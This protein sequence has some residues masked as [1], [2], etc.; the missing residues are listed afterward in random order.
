M[1]PLLP[2]AVHQLAKAVAV[3]SQLV[4][5]TCSSSVS[6]VC[7]S[8]PASPLRLRGRT[9]A[10]TALAWDSAMAA[11]GH[12]EDLRLLGRQEVLCAMLA[13][14]NIQHTGSRNSLLFQCIMIRRPSQD[15]QVQV[16]C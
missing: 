13:S 4:K 7:N 6:S 10:A 11:A 9:C 8:R 14:Y 3:L 15:I 16:A 12:H 2:Q 5:N 1:Q